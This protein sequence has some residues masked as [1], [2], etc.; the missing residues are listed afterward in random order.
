MRSAS[1]RQ[2]GSEGMSAQDAPR[3][4]KSQRLHRVSSSSVEQASVSPEISTLV[5]A[6]ATHS[7]VTFGL[8]MHGVATY[9][10]SACRCLIGIDRD[11][12]ATPLAFGC[13]DVHRP[14]SSTRSCRTTAARAG[15][16]RY[17]S[18]AVFLKVSSMT[19]YFALALSVAFASSRRARSSAMSRYAM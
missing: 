18:R 6:T 12:R 1:W 10:A 9:R 14:I 4:A 3:I 15:A 8:T 2:R 11:H 5:L 19:V 16:S 17:S 7:A 13:A